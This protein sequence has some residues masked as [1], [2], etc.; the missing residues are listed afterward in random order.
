MSEWY[1]AAVCPECGSDDT[2]FV[3]PHEELL[4]YECNTCGARFEKEQDE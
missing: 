2:R 3:E 1:P 4:V